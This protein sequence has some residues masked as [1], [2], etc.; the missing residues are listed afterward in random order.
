MHQVPSK[1][2]GPPE[3]EKKE[4]LLEEHHP[5]WVELLFALIAYVSF[6]FYF[7]FPLFV[8]VFYINYMNALFNRQASERLHGKMTG[9]VSKKKTAQIPNGSR[10]VKFYQHWYNLIGEHAVHTSYILRYNF[11]K[12]YVNS[13]SVF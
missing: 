1:T 4:F 5:I 6:S 3:G 9:F 10:L 11:F 7:F 2:G 8:V 12:K 13:I